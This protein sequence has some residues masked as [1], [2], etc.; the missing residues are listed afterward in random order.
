[1]ASLPPGWKADYDGQRWFFTYGPT[2]QSQFQFPRPGDEFPDFYCCSGAAVPAVELLP[3]EKLES[4]KQVRRMLNVS[5]SGDPGSVGDVLDEKGGF[6]GRET[7]R[8]EKSGDEASQVCFESFVA[9]K[10]RGGQGLGGSREGAKTAKQR[11]SNGNASQESIGVPVSVSLVV[12]GEHT[13]ANSSPH[14]EGGS[15]STIAIMSEPVLAAVETTPP[16]PSL[17]HQGAR[18]PVSAAHSFSPDLPVLGS[19][20]IDSAQKTLSALSVVGIPELYSESTAL[21]EHEINPPPVEL[22]VNEGGWIA[23]MNGSSLAIQSAVELP[24]YAEPGINSEQRKRIARIESTA[25]APLILAEDDAVTSNAGLRKSIEKKSGDHD[26]AGLP[27]QASRMSSKVPHER[28]SPRDRVSSTLDEERSSRDTDQRVE[29]PGTERRDLTH[30]PSILRPGPRRSRQPSLQQPG[31]MMPAPATYTSQ[32]AG[33]QR[34]WQQEQQQKKKVETGSVS[35]GESARMPAMPATPHSHEV[36][37]SACTTGPEAPPQAD[38]PRQNRLPSSVNF[39]VPI[40]HISSVEPSSV[41][42]CAVGT[43]SPKYRVSA[44]FASVTSSGENPRAGA[45]SSEDRPALLPG[46][47]TGSWG[48][49]ADKVT[50]PAR[51]ASG[52]TAAEVPEWSWGFAR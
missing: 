25:C 5:G 2:G 1:M 7:P 38:G 12:D 22:P 50:F 10:T 51:P 17:D 39:V 45:Q 3:E 20:T 21:C 8:L 37:P 43:G 36:Q 44:S 34:Q 47:K 6:S 41:P 11:I 30:F 4:E 9:V 48:Q 28:T 15:I 14:P 18:P 42:D 19:R 29:A 16:A 49:P 23:S 31:P 26:R 13:G 27:S 40:Q 24:A 32:A 35:Q 52:R 46:R 33:V